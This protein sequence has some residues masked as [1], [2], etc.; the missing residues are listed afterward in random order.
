MRV[1]RKL[2]I[3]AF[4]FVGSIPP[5]FCQETGFLNR[6]VTI[7]TAEYRYQVYLPREFRQGVRGQ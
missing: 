3:T 6:S 7:D 1:A 5:A 4:V 2:L